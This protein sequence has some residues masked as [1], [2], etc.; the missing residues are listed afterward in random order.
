MNSVVSK[1]K[2][3]FTFGA[4][5]FK[6]IS[7]D[8]VLSVPDGTRDAY[9][10]K[11][12]T[13]DVFKGGI[14][15]GVN[16]LIPASTSVPQGGRTTF[17]VALENEADIVAV[18]FELQLPTN[19]RIP[20]T[21]NTLQAGLTER[22]NGHTLSCTTLNNGNYQFTASVSPAAAFTSNDGVLLTMQLAS[23]MNVIEGTYDITLKNI[24]LT[25]GDGETIEKPNY[26]VA[27]TVTEVLKGD[28][29][30]DG[31]VTIA[32]VTALVNQILTKQ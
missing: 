19:V 24:V 21:E 28:I 26:T 20:T 8:C 25:K 30:G 4:S 32:D 18:Q 15:E 2:V 6:N 14:E 1:I 11:G 13:E 12:W 27:L 16:K 23:P 17:E 3:P 7:S 22:S 29:D 31:E 9:I 10:A 5:A